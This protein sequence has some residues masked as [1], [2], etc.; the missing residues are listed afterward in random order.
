MLTIRKSD[1]VV[2]K[3]FTIAINDKSTNI[4]I[5]SVEGEENWP[6]SWR[7]LQYKRLGQIGDVSYYQNKKTGVIET[8]N[9]ETVVTVWCKFNTGRKF[10][11]WFRI[12]D[13]NKEKNNAGT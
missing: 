3:Q 6:C 11:Y 5:V 13:V 8:D 1:C 2:G 4:T 12:V 7:D 10:K 9:G